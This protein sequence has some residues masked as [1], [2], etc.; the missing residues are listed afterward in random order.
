MI[1]KLGVTPLC[2]RA[3]LKLLIA[4]WFPRMRE[5]LWQMRESSFVI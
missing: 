1:E 3:S 5:S 4:L 2:G